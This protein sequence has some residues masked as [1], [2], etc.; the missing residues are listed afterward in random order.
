[1]VGNGV[2]SVC[3]VGGL[4]KKLVGARIM[5]VE[6]V[7]DNK[8][9]GKKKEEEKMKED[10]DGKPPHCYPGY[11][12]HHQYPSHMIVCDEPATSYCAIL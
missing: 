1:V 8:E 5:K 6:E 3:I 4:R 10:E 2:D 9:E 7:K 11:Y 12:Y